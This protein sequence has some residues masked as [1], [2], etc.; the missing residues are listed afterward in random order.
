MKAISITYRLQ[1]N[2]GKHHEFT[3]KLNGEDLSLCESNETSLPSWAQLDFHQCLDCP[4]NASDSPYCPAA[5]SLIPLAEEIT[6]IQ[7]YDSMHAEIIYNDRTVSLDT[8]A[9]RIISSML[10]LLMAVSGCPNTEFLRPMARFHIPLASEEETIYRAA[11]MY[12]L[13]QYFRMRENLIPDLAMDGLTHQYQILQRVNKSM[14]DRLRSAEGKDAGVNAV[15]LLDL[16]AKAMPQSVEESM[17][18]L[19][20][21]FSSYLD[22]DFN[23]PE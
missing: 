3:I 13:A 9:Q 14:A 1:A 6:D 22:P 2:S 16:F 18:E 12:L 19:R 10:G 11:S 7:S 20:Y 15:I 21:L 5:V 17:L 8:S 4:L 23:P